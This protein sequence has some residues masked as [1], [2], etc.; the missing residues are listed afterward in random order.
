[1]ATPQITATRTRREASQYSSTTCIARLSYVPSSP[2]RHYFSLITRH[3]LSIP[4]C[5]HCPHHRLTLPPQVI[6]SGGCGQEQLL[7]IRLLV[8]VERA[9]AAHLLVVCTERICRSCRVAESLEQARSRSGAHTRTRA[10]THRYMSNVR[11]GI[12]VSVGRSLRV[13]NRTHVHQLLGIPVGR[14]GKKKARLRCPSRHM[15]RAWKRRGRLLSHTCSCSWP[16]IASA[17]RS[18]ARPCRLSSLP[19]TAPSRAAQDAEWN[20]DYPPGDKLY[21]TLARRR[22][23]TSIQFQRVHGGRSELLSCS[24]GC[25]TQA[26]PIYVHI[27][28]YIY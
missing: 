2:P 28:S 22:G 8:H 12:F 24:D 14:R 10:R 7:G 9:Y 13:R 23:Y 15:A 27:L 3:L 20:T 17:S 16:L 26:P 11:T 4:P 19:P 6:P 5:H 18:L 25:S 21:C 1:M